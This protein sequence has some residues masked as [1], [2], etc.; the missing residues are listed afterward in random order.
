MSKVSVILLAGGKGIRLGANIP[1]QYLEI[2]GKPIAL[3]SFE[4]LKPFGEM[5]V[6]AHPQYRAIFP[7]EAVTFAEPGLRRQDSVFNG[8]QK[9]TGEWVL[10]HDAARPFLKKEEVEALLAQKDD[11]DALALASPVKSTLKQVDDNLNV[12]QTIPRK[13]LWEVHTPQLIKREILEMA[14]E[15]VEGEV[16]DDLSLAELVG[17]KV[18]LIKGSEGNVKITTQEDLKYA[19]V[20]IDLSV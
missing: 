10:I 13:G 4:T 14:F 19:K 8:L 2:K 15:I 3:Y 18:K 1:K 20:C 12:L 11:A 6:V 17:A 5:V 9:A 7:K 16:T